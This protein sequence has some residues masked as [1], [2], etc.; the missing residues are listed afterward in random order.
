[1]PILSRCH[2]WSIL[3]W[4]CTSP[5]CLSTT[6]D[7]VSESYA[8]FL[9]LSLPSTNAFRC[10]LGGLRGSRR[11]ATCGRGGDLLIQWAALPYYGQTPW[12]RFRCSITP[13]IT[14][15]MMRTVPTIPVFI[16]P[17]VRV[18]FLFP[19]RI[20][21]R[22]DAQCRDACGQQ[23]FRVVTVVALRHNVR[24]RPMGCFRIRSLELYVWA[25]TNDK[26]FTNFVLFHPIDWLKVKW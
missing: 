1:M 9:F 2:H 4:I 20:I 12:S 5:E 6:F 8:S 24:W 14:L 11:W 23:C 15:H 17:L 7:P 18:S 10:F 25:V 13:S 16:N 19:Y 3:T 21:V 22:K 26:G